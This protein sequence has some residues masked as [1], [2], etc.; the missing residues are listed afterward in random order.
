MFGIRKKIHIYDERLKKTEFI[1]KCVFIYSYMF[2]L[3][4]PSKYSFDA[5][6]L[7]R[8]FLHCSKQ[9]LNSSVFMPFFV[10]KLFH[11]SK[12][13][14]FED[15]FHPGGKKNLTEGKIRWL[16]RVGHEDHAIFGQKLPNTQCSVGRCTHK[17]PMAN[18]PN[19]F[20]KPLEKTSLKPNAASHNARWYTDTDRF[21][22]HSPSWGNLYYKRLTLQKVILIFWVPFLYIHSALW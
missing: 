11:I 13:F 12:T 20:K 6:H 4:S 5:I 2:K 9:F 21:L 1:K 10:S 14:P 16:G 19:M 3:Q 15:F 7:L 17:S 22:E 18:W 8:H